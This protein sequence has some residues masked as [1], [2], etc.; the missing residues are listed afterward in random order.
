LHRQIPYSTIPVAFRWPAAR[1]KW[2]AA[3]KVSFAI[4]SAI[5]SGFPNWIYANALRSSAIFL[6]A[7][8]G[9]DAIGDDGFGELH[10]RFSNP[11]DAFYSRNPA[12]V[13][14]EPFQIDIFQACFFPKLI[15]NVVEIW[16]FRRNCFPARA[17]QLRK[18]FGSRS[19]NWRTLR[20]H[21]FAPDQPLALDV[22]EE[23]EFRQGQ[24]NHDSECLGLKCGISVRIGGDFRYDRLG[25]TASSCLTDRLAILAQR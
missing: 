14:L 8:R 12:L 4:H 22:V 3:H 7:F 13:F 16:P 19:R 5:W 9:V 20:R 2:I 17:N 11:A 23:F 10:C 15:N 1:L 24:V 6:S 18:A 21:S 25:G